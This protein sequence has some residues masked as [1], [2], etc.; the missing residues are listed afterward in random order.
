M[1]VIPATVRIINRRIVAMWGKIA[2]KRAGNVSLVVECLLSKH[3]T[4]SS[5]PILIPL[6]PSPKKRHG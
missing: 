4:L 3:G 2:A 1:S 6:F 5:N